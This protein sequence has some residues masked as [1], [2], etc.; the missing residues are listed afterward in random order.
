[1]GFISVPH[2]AKITSLK[3]NGKYKGSLLKARA[4]KR[5]EF[6]YEENSNLFELLPQSVKMII[7]YFGRIK[8]ELILPP[9]LKRLNI[10]VSYIDLNK[11]GIVHARNL[12][13]LILSGSGTTCLEIISQLTNLTHLTFGY[14]FDQR[15]DNLPENLIYLCLGSY[16]NQRIDNLP[17]KLKYLILCYSFDTPIDSLPPGLLELSLGS[18]FNQKINHLPQALRKLKLGVEFNKEIDH[19]PSSLRDLVLGNKFNQKVDKLPSSL[20]NITF[21][22]QF[23]QEVKFLPSG[24][25]EITIGINF[26]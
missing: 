22:S 19:L 21:G 12:T 23:N 20:R 4:L 26:N 11:L 24:I 9:N 6:S 2:L 7:P 3:I 1:M 5:V 8:S 17:S 18:K 10:S 25:R 16:F 14:H 15:I 13:H